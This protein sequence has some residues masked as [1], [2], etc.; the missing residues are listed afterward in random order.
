MLRTV[1]SLAL[2]LCDPA[3]ALVSEVTGRGFAASVTNRSD[4]LH[5]VK[6]YAPWCN[7][8]K[9]LAPTL[10]EVSDAMP[11]INFRVVRVDCTDKDI[12]PYEPKGSIANDKFCD[13][14]G[15]KGFPT[16]Y[17]VQGNLKWEYLGERSPD[18]L[19]DAAQR[20]LA[21]P[22]ADVATPE[23][24]QPLLTPGVVVF[25]LVRAPSS[26]RAHR[27]FES[28]ARYRQ[29]NT[30]VFAAT[31]S[32]RVLEL[33]IGPDAAAVA[34]FPLV[35]KV[36]GGEAS[37]VLRGDELDAMERSAELDA[38][39]GARRAPTLSLVDLTSS[40]F[41]DLRVDTPPLA[42]LLVPSPP[43]RNLTHADLGRPPADALHAIARSFDGFHYGVADGGLFPTWTSDH[44]LTSDELPCLIVLF[45]RASTFAVGAP[46]HA[47]EPSMRA[48]LERVQEG[49]YRAV[50]E[51]FYVGMPGRWYAH[52][53]R[54]YPGLAPLD[55]LPI[56]CIALP[57]TLLA[58]WAYWNFVVKRL[59][60][61]SGGKVDL[62]AAQKKQ[63]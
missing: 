38:W 49:R 61:A 60:L 31:D 52:Y 26:H 41:Y 37:L 40:S 6:F 27:L 36:Q 39:I 35:A 17:F 45:G 53:R 43:G 16:L 51:G 62:S 24:L 23:E 46:G 47:D 20:M 58:L 42:L 44:H 3:L 22:V 28:V 9:R 48:F 63:Q 11:D 34:T 5:L 14:W 4:T 32:P 30:T 57:L 56:G 8:C 10:I 19:I 29:P 15:V 33:A 18:A 50:W 25:L 21:P 55:V 59:A 2:L 1:A 13:D 7:H 12:P 54:K